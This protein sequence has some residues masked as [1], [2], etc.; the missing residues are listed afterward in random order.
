MESF[1]H[2]CWIMMI[3]NYP[4]TRL[5]TI[6]FR[7]SMILLCAFVSQLLSVWL[8]RH[9]PFHHRR[10]QQAMSTGDHNG[11]APEGVLGLGV[12]HESRGFQCSG[13]SPRTACISMALT[14]SQRISATPTVLCILDAHVPASDAC[15]AEAQHHHHHC[16]QSIP[17]TLPD[18]AQSPVTPSRVRWIP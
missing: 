18:S 3:R 7:H 4:T 14:R 1:I 2:G 6:Q 13:N 11:T 9:R 10:Q 15:P 17:P 12:Q 5:F 16:A 8:S